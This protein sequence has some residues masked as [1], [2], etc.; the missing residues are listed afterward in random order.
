MQ[1]DNYTTRAQYV[2]TGN[3]LNKSVDTSQFVEA[4][5]RKINF[6][7]KLE[8]L[9]IRNEIVLSGNVAR[10]NLIN[11]V[12]TVD[13]ELHSSFV[14]DTEINDEDN[15]STGEVRKKEKSEKEKL[16]ENILAVQNKGKA[17]AESMKQDQDIG[18]TR[19]AMIRKVS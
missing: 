8:E 14:N 19:N 11:E 6:D 7:K 12:G 9:S 10:Q 16:D 13:K 4:N 5:R 3:E 18:L 15:T 2:R 17:I 1:E